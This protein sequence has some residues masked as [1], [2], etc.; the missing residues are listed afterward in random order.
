MAINC[1]ELREKYLELLLAGGEVLIKSGDQLVKYTDAE[2]L[3]NVIEQICGPIRPEGSTA[4][5]DMRLH[6]N[7]FKDSADCGCDS[8]R[9]WD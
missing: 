8:K 9:G 4:Q 1:D 6:G 3:K 2:K 5:R 7:A